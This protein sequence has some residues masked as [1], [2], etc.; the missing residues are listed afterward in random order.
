MGWVPLST[1]TNADFIDFDI[2]D[3]IIANL[4]YLRDAVPEI[5]VQRPTGVWLSS[6]GDVDT[7]LVIQGGQQTVPAFT[8]IHDIVVKLK[9]PHVGSPDYPVTLTAYSHIDVRVFLYSQNNKQFVV[10]II[11]TTRSSIRGLKVNWNAITYEG[12]TSA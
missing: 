12:T 4:N 8:G 6:S 2:M 10:R 9:K 3:Q 7:R 5:Y 11:P 1:L